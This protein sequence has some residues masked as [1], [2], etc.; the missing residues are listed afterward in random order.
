[1]SV[2]APPK[3]PGRRIARSNASH[4]FLTAKLVIQIDSVLTSM[5]VPSD[6]GFPLRAELSQEEVAAA[7]PEVAHFQAAPIRGTRNNQTQTT[8]G[9]SMRRCSISAH[10]YAVLKPYGRGLSL[11]YPLKRRSNRTQLNRRFPSPRRQVP[12]GV[13]SAVCDLLPLWAWLSHPAVAVPGELQGQS[14]V[15]E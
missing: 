3:Q 14:C 2:L 12:G 5:P 15:P 1:M 13:F 11:T 9:K 7:G 6:W 10:R 4:H 8:S